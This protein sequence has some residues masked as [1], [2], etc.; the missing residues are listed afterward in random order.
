MSN[1]TSAARSFSSSSIPLAQISLAHR[2]HHRRTPEFPQHQ[3]LLILDHSS[4]TSQPLL[5]LNRD[6]HRKRELHSQDVKPTGR[7]PLQCLPTCL[8]ATA[9][10]PTSADGRQPRGSR[11]EQSYGV[12]EWACWA[13]DSAFLVC[14]TRFSIAIAIA[15]AELGRAS[16][17]VTRDTLLLSNP[18][19]R[20]L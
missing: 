14:R 17:R 10:P 18:Q 11:T 19:A 13:E 15:I 12:S 20:I 9:A 1:S 3:Q 5:S 4:Q 7:P 6:S 16:G 2:R 8:P